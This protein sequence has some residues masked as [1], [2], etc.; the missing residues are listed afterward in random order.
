MKRKYESIKNFPGIYKV[1]ISENG[2]S[3]KEPERGCRYAA[4]RY[5]ESRSGTQRSK[6]HFRT[7][8]DAKA[9]RMRTQD[10]SHIN[11]KTKTDGFLFEDLI[12]LY[13]RTV[14]SNRAASTAARYPHYLKHF[15]FFKG[16]AVED[17]DTLTIDSW[18]SW[19]KR[20]EYLATQHTTRCNYNHEFSL[21]RGMLGVYNSRINRNYRMPFIKDHK[22]AL[23]VKE[24][25][26]IKKD[27]TPEEFERF[28]ISLKKICEGTKGDFVYYLALF[29]YFTFSRIQEASALH[30]EDFDFKR[31]EV[32]IN[33]KLLFGRSKK[34]QTTL[35]SGAKANGGKI[36]PITEMLSKIFREWT[37]RSG[38]RQGPLF[39]T[40]AAWPSYR[41][42]S[43]RYTRALKLAGLPYTATHILR[44]AS[45]TEAQESSGDLN[46]TK[47]LAGHRSTKTTERY[48]K[49][50]SN[51]VRET[52]AKLDFKHANILHGSQR[53]AFDGT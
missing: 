18:I 10:D 31:G 14:M 4:S 29:Q 46:Q 11:Q 17:I 16:M 19:L 24:A 35:E 45:L 13:E 7:F 49:V 2:K 41:F 15:D 27:L 51:Q 42:I 12:A 43:H 21:L 25:P 1:L 30:Y 32:S 44:H 52:Q 23:K 20:P 3:W 28:L 37:L 40:G 5:E 34:E 9:F 33:K 39:K 38:V 48:A 8:D 53:F 50:R 22:S 36:I 6:R 26:L 47:F